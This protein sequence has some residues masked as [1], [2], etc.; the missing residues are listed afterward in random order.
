MYSYDSL[1]TLD[2]RILTMVEDPTKDLQQDRYTP[3]RC[4]LET[5]M[6]L[7]KVSPN[8]K[9]TARALSIG[10]KAGLLT[11]ELSDKD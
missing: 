2:V 8:V 9:E 5:V 3:L 4:E 7:E 1:Y 6:T 11:Q 10:T